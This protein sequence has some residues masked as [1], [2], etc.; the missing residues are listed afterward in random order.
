MKPYLLIAAL[1]ASLA[2][3][4]SNGGEDRGARDAQTAFPLRIPQSD[5]QTLV[6]EKAPRRIVSLSAAATEVL[7]A[8]GAGDSLAAVDKYAN[9]PAGSKARPEIDSFQP[10]L[11][12]I[13]ALQPDLVYV[14][15]DQGGIVGA[16]RGIG[17]P[18][19]FLKPADSIA[20]VLEN[21]AL[22]GRVTERAPEAASIVDAMQK[23]RDGVTSRLASVNRGPRAFHELSPD[24]YT[25]RNDTFTGELYTLLKADNIAAGSATAY[26]QLSAEV[27]VA[28]DPEVIILADGSLPAE[29]RA[30]PGWAGVSAVRNN[31]FCSVDP[32]LVSRPGPRIIDGLE[33]LAACL[34]PAP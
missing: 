32:D 17:V 14:F 30:R 11:E 12:A 27:I 33:A 13:A 25:V 9:C 20:G 16:L 18:V 22:L 8:I 29:V 31:R 4:C 3:A 19:L 10:S 23:R 15:S 1:I 24:Y 7:C 34:Y 5:G 6:L 28:R 2:I 26:P 21:I